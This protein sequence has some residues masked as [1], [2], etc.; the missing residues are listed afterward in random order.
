MP[1]RVRC[2][3]GTPRDRVV[4]AAASQRYRKRNVRYEVSS[5]PAV[6]V[7]GYN[8][9]RGISYVRRRD[10]RARLFR[11]HI[12]TVR[13]AL[14]PR[15]GA[16]YAIQRTSTALSRHVST[17][18][19]TAQLPSA[20]KPVPRATRPTADAARGGM[21]KQHIR[22]TQTIPIHAP[23]DLTA[24]TATRPLCHAKATN[25]P[26]SCTWAPRQRRGHMRLRLVQPSPASPRY[27]HT[28]GVVPAQPEAF[29]N[30]PLYHRWARGTR[31]RGRAP[32]APR[33]PHSHPIM[34][35]YR[36]PTH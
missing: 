32:L 31:A 13:K 15:T 10:R 35:L 24:S 3:R 6:C 16:E 9:V 27:H 22:R 36:L 23:Y 33:P 28:P 5:H 19:C 7:G 34:T 8:V 21:R 18:I 12:H 17:I 14:R 30:T 11:I 1:Y 2:G 29:L 4:R 25:K 20:P 26:E